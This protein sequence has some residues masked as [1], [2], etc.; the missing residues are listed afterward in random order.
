MTVLFSISVQN[1]LTKAFLVL[2]SRMFTFA[3]NFAIRKIRGCWLHI[4]QWLFRISAKKYPNKATFVQNVS[5][6]I[7]CMELR[8]SRVNFKKS[9]V[10][11]SKMAIVFSNSSLK[12]P[13][14]SFFCE[15]LE[16]FSFYVKLWVNLILFN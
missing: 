14:S 11:I 15:R 13:K 16:V 7:F 4:R 5:F 8:K 10:L 6:F 3:R 1:Y 2:N 9:R 12:I